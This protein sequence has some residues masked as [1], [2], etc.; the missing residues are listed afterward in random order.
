MTLYDGELKGM[1]VASCQ[2]RRFAN[3]SSEEEDRRE[4]ASAVFVTV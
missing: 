4:E 1:N 2:R 3:R